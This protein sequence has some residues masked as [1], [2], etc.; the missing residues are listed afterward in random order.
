M[1]Q[2]KIDGQ[3]F[4]YSGPAFHYLNEEERHFFAK[5]APQFRVNV[6]GCGMIGMEHMRVATRVG[7][8][9]IHGVFD[10][11]ERSIKV[12]KEEYA[13]ESSSELVV[14]SS[15]EDA[16]N[17]PA[18]DGILICT[19]NY[20]HLD[21]L[22]T[23]IKSGKHI[24]ME[25]PM[26]TKLQDAYEITQMAKDY[27]A[28]L[29][30]GLQY[31][32]KSIYAEA[33]HEVLERKAIGQVKMINLL[34][35]RIP[36]LDKVGQWNKF[37]QYSGGTLVEKCCHYFD[38]MNLFA[39]SRPVR[40]HATGS[41]STNF[42]NFEFKGAKSDILDS[43]FVTVE[44]ENGVRAGFN[45]CMFAPMFHEEIV[46]C[47]DEGRVKAAE[48]EDFSESARLRTEMEVFC[49]QNR[50]SKRSEPMYPKLIED[51]GHNGA[52]W[53]EHIAFADRMAG[54]E[55]D[56]ATMEDGFWSVVVGT[57]AQEAIRTGKVIDINAMLKEANIPL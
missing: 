31:R 30:I 4:S 49:G 28:V 38:L 5:E 36:F 17:D 6:I 23:V 3:L 26:A 11:N 13:K 39:Q 46:I 25:K 42:R 32:Y 44:Y 9:A 40:V 52:T 50:P 47:G 8:T 53:F 34:E 41:Q 20:T 55:T 24:F 7:R 54:K 35:H 1:S 33:I 19:P 57:A 56:S 15:L 14:Y 2:E 18:V 10:T 16:C 45:L 22:K 43:A 48:I 51:S 12:A 37:N 27:G 21:V 29:Q